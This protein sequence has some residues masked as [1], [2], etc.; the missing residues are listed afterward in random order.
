MKKL[1]RDSW[2]AI[3]LFITLTFVTLIAGIYQVKAQQTA[4]PLA[5][6]SSSPD[7]AKALWLWLD[8]LGYPVSD[9]VGK[10]FRPSKDISLLLILEPLT[11]ITA[12]E[13]QT[14]DAWVEDGGTLVL[15]GDYWPTSRALR[16]YDFALGVPSFHRTYSELEVT[17]LTA[18]TPLLASPPLTL[19][20]RAKL[21][22]HLSYYPEDKTH[23]RDFVAHLTDDDGLVMVSFEEGDGRVILCTAPFVFSNAGLKEEGNPALVLN[24]V[25]AT[26]RTGVILFDE[27]HHG[28][29]PTSSQVVGPADWLRYTP[30]GRSLLY[31]ALVTFV[32]L[33]LHGR[34]FGRPVP[35]PKAVARRAPLEYITA[36]ANLKRQA[37]HRTAVMRY[38][39]H[40][41]K[42]KLGKRYRLDSTLPD[43][44]Y[45][46]QLAE[47]SPNL[48]AQALRSLL[49]RLRSPLSESEMIQVAAQV[50]EWLE[51][52]T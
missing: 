10:E 51:G 20:V 24:V 31:V 9:E 47:L 39:R 37:G 16:H 40:Q 29:Q 33:V 48:D 49:A 19:P 28:L 3:G 6:F 36:I 38:Y 44:E 8:E 52:V 21:Q 1:S 27:W 50:A 18:Q 41:L 15:V 4:P 17:P 26:N 13:W 35:L 14:I 42:R 30:A 2:L 45:V 23:V 32:A 22:A 12:A 25:L 46:A 11:E 5:S 43:D 7:G 34:H